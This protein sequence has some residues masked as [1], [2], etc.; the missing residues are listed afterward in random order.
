M[1]K[2][3]IRFKSI[4]LDLFVTAICICAFFFS[5]KYFFIEL[6]RNTVRTDISSIA[7][8]QYKYKTAQRKFKD[9]VVWERLQQNSTLYNG[10]IIRTASQATA[11]ILFSNNSSLELGENTMLQIFITDDGDYVI[12]LDSGTI[13]V[14]SENVENNSHVS[15]QMKNGAALTL[16]PGAAFSAETNEDG[17]ASFTVKQGGVTVTDESG[18]ELEMSQGESFKQTQDGKISKKA[19]SASSPSQVLNFEEKPVD[20]N[21]DWTVI[22]E[23]KSEKLIIETSTTPD[24]SN[25]QNKYTKA[26]DDKLAIPVEEGKV[27]W[28]VY[29]ESD[30]ENKTTGDFNVIKASSFNLI[31]PSDNSQ[32]KLTDKLTINFNWE[33]GEQVSHYKFQLAKDS[34]FNNIITE[35]KIFDTKYNYVLDAENQTETKTDYYWRVVPYYTIGNQGYRENVKYSSFS[36]EKVT[37]EVIARPELIYP[38]DKQ[39]VYAKDKE[40]QLTFMWDSEQ[41]MNSYSLIVSKSRDFSN[42]LVNLKTENSVSVQPVTNDL[43]GQGTYYWKVVGYTDGEN[44][45]E[46]ITKTF[47]VQKE[48]G[49]PVA[50]VLPEDKPESFEKSAIEIAMEKAGQ[51]LEITIEKNQII[52][53]AEIAGVEPEKYV[54]IAK[55]ETAATEKVV[56][57]VKTEPKPKPQVKPVEKKK[58]VVEKKPVEEKKPVVEKQPEKVVEQPKVEEPVIETKV[59]E[60]IPLKDPVLLEPVKDVTI[61]TEYIKTNRKVVFIWDSVEDATDYTFDLYQIL[62]SGGKKRVFQQKNI[63]QNRFEFTELTKLQNGNF[64]WRVTAYK[65]T[66]VSETTI[67]SK[68]SIQNFSIQIGLPSKVNPI[69]PG[70][71][72]GD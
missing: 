41:K 19:V 25:I 42:T 32:M 69:D 35:Q 24:F 16:K 72:Y 13:A 34:S 52:E 61:D 20:V 6:N 1:G 55:T 63:E 4:L 68:Q 28:R 60:I 3:R 62:P 36:V 44:A 65:H 23:Y 67:H 56:E 26:P 7:Q 33:E 38:I 64:E 30:V 51:P 47:E 70:K 45:V 66:G 17:E 50:L 40:S 5:L 37:Q 39:V 53:K 8:V 15:L 71:Q 54:E 11:T 31:S 59:V 2:K 49:E 14:E 43:Y 29:P 18:I 48:P 22:P 27:Y 21:I 9:R 57:S 10:D 12:S 46:S 58:P